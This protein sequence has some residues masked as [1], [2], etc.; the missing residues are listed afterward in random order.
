MSLTETSELAS[1]TR[2][3]FPAKQW[4]RRSAV[5]TTFFIFVRGL[6]KTQ[7]RVGSYNNV[8]RPFVVWWVWMRLEALAPYV[9]HADY[10]CLAMLQR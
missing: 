3:V 9:F 7:L 1:S 8:V 4:R 6:S 10:Y 2:G 5:T